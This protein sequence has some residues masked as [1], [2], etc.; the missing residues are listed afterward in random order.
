MN[1]K[2][3]INA[4]QI[5]AA[6]GFDSKGEAVVSVAHYGDELRWLQGWK[7]DWKKTWEPIPEDKMHMLEDLEFR[8]Y[9]AKPADQIEAEVLAALSEIAD[10]YEHEQE[11]AA[12]YFE[13]M[14]EVEF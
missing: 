2:E 1:Y 11:D 3:A 5:W 8:P 14:G 12:N 6:R 9:G 7:G 10:E 4:S 13:P